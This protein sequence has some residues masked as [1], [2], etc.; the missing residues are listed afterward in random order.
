MQFF[1]GL[2]LKV[3]DLQFLEER[4]AGGFGLKVWD[5]GPSW[6]RVYMRFLGLYVGF[7]KLWLPS[8][9]GYLQQGLSNIAWN[10]I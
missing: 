8:W 2:G 4:A 6:R 7:P 9:G 10:T 5:L 1:L 3:N